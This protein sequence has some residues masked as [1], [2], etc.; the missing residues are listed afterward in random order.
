M[1]SRD[2]MGHG[3]DCRFRRTIGWIVKTQS[4]RLRYDN[5]A[6]HLRPRVLTKLRLKPT[7]EREDAD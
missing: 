3:S 7:S 4:S 1:A 5:P 6:V 2:F